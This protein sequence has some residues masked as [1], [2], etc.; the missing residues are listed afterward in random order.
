MKTTNFSPEVRLLASNLIP[1]YAESYGEW[2]V[3][4][5]A[6]HARP[7]TWGSQESNPQALQL[8]SRN[9]LEYP[10]ALWEVGS[11]KPFTKS[12]VEGEE[13]SLTP[14]EQTQLLQ[15]I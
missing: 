10:F 1:I 4:S 12:S 9:L 14:P 3:H 6:W 2:F 13:Q 7:T 5:L 15:S 11:S 8:A